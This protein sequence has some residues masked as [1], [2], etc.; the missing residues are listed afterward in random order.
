MKSNSA[1]YD[2]Y[3]KKPSLVTDP[4]KGK[5]DETPSGGTQEKE[6]EEPIIP[7]EP[8]VETKPNITNSLPSSTK[9]TKG[10]KKTLQRFL[11]NM[12][13]NAGTVDGV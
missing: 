3:A 8:A 9:L 5:G 2:D 7:A 11:N 12:G 13:Y 10:Q 6:E 4:Q 1:V